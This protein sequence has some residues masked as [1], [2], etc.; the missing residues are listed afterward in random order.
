[1]ETTKPNGSL[2]NIVDNLIFEP[3]TNPE[4]EAEET[5]EATDDTQTETVED[6][7]VVED[8]DEVSDIDEEIT[9]TEDELEDDAAVPFELSDDMELEYKSDG[10]M[11]KATIGEL[12]RSAAGQ[13]Y[14]QKGM[15]ENA[16]VKKELEAAKQEF[17]QQQQQVA[18]ER[19]ALMQMAQQMQSGNIPAIPQPP[20]EEL[21]ASDPVGWT[22]AEAEYRQALDDRNKWENNVKAMAER[23]AIQK[24]N[25]EKQFL[26][27]QAMRLQDWMPEFADPE[28]R[29]LFIQDMTKKAEKHYKLTPEQMATVKTAD[30]VMIL[31]DALKYRE[32]MANKSNAKKKAKDARPTVV[33]PSARKSNIAGK[34]SRAKT[35]KA[36]MKQTGSIDDVAKW[37]ST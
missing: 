32:L 18:Q 33:T 24:Q 14:I 22:I 10:E 9:D 8:V 15:A 36:N 6:A 1:V 11:K 29:A 3:P 2:D 20:S 5:V 17:A 28:K 4:P 30:E 16:S 23:E 19:Q 27:Q 26:S 12:K 21:K 31:T 35:A 25:E 7:E 13:D 34:A 37:L